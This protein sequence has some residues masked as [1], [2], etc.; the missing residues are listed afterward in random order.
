MLYYTI[1]Y[2]ILLYYESPGVL[3]FRIP[4]P[5]SR[6]LPVGS[7]IVSRRQLPG[8]RSKDGGR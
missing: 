7:G 4:G 1:P 8:V 3:E 5:T 2:Y 6:I